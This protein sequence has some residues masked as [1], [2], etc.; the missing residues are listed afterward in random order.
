[1]G[2][3]SRTIAAPPSPAAVK[4]ATY[5]PLPEFGGPRNRSAIRRT[6]AELKRRAPF[7]FEPTPGGLGLSG[8]DC[9]A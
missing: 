9:A 8:Q 4:P 3:L 7:A 6:R 1:M 5:P 2:A